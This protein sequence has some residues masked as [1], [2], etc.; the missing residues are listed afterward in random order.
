MAPRWRVGD[1]SLFVCSRFSPFGIE[2]EWE[3]L[4]TDSYVE[5]GGADGNAKVSRD[6]LLRE[7]AST[8]VAAAS[9]AA[10]PPRFSAA[11]PL[12]QVPTSKCNSHENQL[13][14]CVSLWHDLVPM[15]RIRVR[16]RVICGQGTTLLQL[17]YIIMP[18]QNGKINYILW[19]KMP[20]KPFVYCL[21]VGN[22]RA[23]PCQASTVLV[24]GFLIGK[25]FK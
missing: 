19:L 3:V 16:V 23:R 4:L 12:L 6:L 22:W 20:I 8:A 15:T 1:E 24:K 9:C 25:N 14:L 17:S 18:R 11:F 5:V 2:F 21:A 13:W 7:R 10:P